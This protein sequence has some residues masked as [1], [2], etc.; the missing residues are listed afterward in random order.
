MSTART[1]RSSQPPA[2]RRPSRRPIGRHSNGML[3]TPEEFDRRSDFDDRYRY[4]LIHGVLVVSPAPGISERDPN[5]ELEYLLRNYKWNH[6]SGTL[7]DKTVSEEYIYLPDGRRRADR[8][9]WIGLGRIPEPGKDVPAIAIEIVSNRQRDRV[10]DYEEKRREYLAA[11]VQEY[12]GIDRFRRTMT[13]Y[14]KEPAEP[15]E[16][17]VKEGEV[18][19]TPL[20][21]GFEL[22]LA[23]LLQAADDW[24][25]PA[26]PAPADPK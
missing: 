25:R 13:V 24:K 9:V 10:R 12:W 19:A 18:Y 23:R 7:I 26:A 4:E 6:P 5:G 16:V 2:P 22:P 11:G 1:R 3:M 14:R 17:V 20:L 8:V 21:P 15:A